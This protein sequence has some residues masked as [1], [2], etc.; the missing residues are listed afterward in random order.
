MGTTVSV[1][2]EYGFSDIARGPQGARGPTGERGLRGVTGELGPTGLQGITGPRGK[3]GVSGIGAKG[4]IAPV[5]FYTD[6]RLGNNDY[7]AIYEPLIS[8]NYR[9]YGD[10]SDGR[11]DNLIRLQII[12]VVGGR[13]VSGN[14]YTS[15]VAGTY[16][17]S[18]HVGHTITT[19][20]A[21]LGFIDFG[22]SGS[23]RCYI[24]SGSSNYKLQFVPYEPPT[25]QVYDIYSIAVD[26]PPRKYVFRDVDYSPVLGNDSRLVTSGGIA[27]SYCSLIDK[28]AASKGLTAAQVAQMKA[29]YGA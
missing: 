10:Y 21:S 26:D 25:G 4:A 16:I 15:T 14:I 23:Y 12:N 13:M 24:S 17:N 5:T 20:P 6:D 19:F 2:D 27:T 8:G 3:W 22:T 9:I 18:M 1:W 29:L 7:Q 11:G 28:I